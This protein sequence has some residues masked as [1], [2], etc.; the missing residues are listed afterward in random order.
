MHERPGCPG[1]PA[2]D[3]LQQ[4]PGSKRPLPAAPTHPDWRTS[5]MT[6]I[7]SSGQ[8]VVAKVVP[9]V[10]PNASPQVTALTGPDWTTLF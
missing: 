2:T 1:C 4:V 6:G 7:T 3:G 10:V 5:R 9:A 8:G